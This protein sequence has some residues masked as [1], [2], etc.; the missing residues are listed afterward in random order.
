M[1]PNRLTSS[2]LVRRVILAILVAIITPA[3][4]FTAEPKSE[5]VLIVYFSRVGISES[6]AG[7]DAVSSASLPEGNTIVIANMIHDEIGGELHQI[8]TVKK[9]PGNYRKTTEIALDEQ[10]RGARPKLSRDIGDLDSYDTVFLGYPNWWGTIPMAV[11][12]FLEAHDLSGK[13]VIP[14]V[15]HGGSALGTSVRDIARICPNAI[16]KDGLAIY[17]SDVNRSRNR[18][19]EWLRKLGY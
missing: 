5:K 8:T 9:Y 19:N 15:T 6:F 16:I 4:L 14:F 3:F 18:V 12:T 13:N 10:K 17:A 11:F 1:R 2:R 7:E